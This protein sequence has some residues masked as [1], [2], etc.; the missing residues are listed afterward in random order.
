MLTLFFILVIHPVL[1]N[2]STQSIPNVPLSNLVQ[3]TLYLPEYLSF[4]GTPLYNQIWLQGNVKILNEIHVGIPLWYDIYSDD[5]IMIRLEDGE[6]LFIKLIKEFIPEFFLDGR[7]FI[8][9]E[10]SMLRHLLLPSGFYELF[11]NGT[12]KMLLKRRKRL[13]RKDSQD[14]FVQDDIWYLIIDD[15]VYRVKGK[16][17]LWQALGKEFKK[18]IQSFLSSN[19]IRVRKATDADWKKISSFINNLK[20]QE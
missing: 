15:Q 11:Y 13:T 19:R 10:Y 8:N 20:E 6:I 9:L 7:R 14:A 18:P 1:Y 16:K 4:N 3:G 5:L 12:I 2:Q 17:D